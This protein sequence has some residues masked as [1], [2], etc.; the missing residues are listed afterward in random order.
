[1]TNLIKRKRRI[2]NLKIFSAFLISFILSLINFACSEENK[3]VKDFSQIAPKSLRK[4]SL[5]IFEEK[6][7]DSIKIKLYQRIDYLSIDSVVEV[8]KSLLPDRFH[9][10]KKFKEILY[11]GKDS[12]QFNEWVYKDTNNLKQALYNLM[13]CFESPCVSFKMYESKHVSKSNFIILCSE[14]TMILIKSS[15]EIK[16][17]EWLIFLEKEKGYKSFELIISQSKH[18]KTKWFSSKYTNLT[19]K[20]K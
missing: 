11:F 17:S 7:I 3:N 16:L 12:L 18:G 5:N 9:P 10:I 13:D 15:I 1:M 6:N 2:K 19:P 8:S 14:K 4:D 20:T